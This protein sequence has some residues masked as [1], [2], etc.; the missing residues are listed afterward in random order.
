[1]PEEPQE[2]TEQEQG[3]LIAHARRCLEEQVR[4]G[5]VSRTDDAWIDRREILR[6]KRGLFVTLKKRGELRG[7]IGDLSAS[8]PLHLGVRK[9]T[10]D[11]AIH[12]PRF[13]AVGPD[14]LDEI[15]LSISILTPSVPIEYDDPEEL[16]TLLEPHRDGVTLEFE[17][18]RSTFLPQVWSQLPE[19][20]LF[21]TRLC[22]KQ[23]SPRNAWRSP[24]A[25]VFRYR[26]CVFGETEDA[27]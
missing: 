16:L 12:D 4:E 11:A 13:P 22:L 21:L 1:V 17:G 8:Q 23:G 3:E 9:A 6:K 24:A 27:E 7:C 19:P 25:R 26:A 15:E 2:P 10:V 20:E 5:R 18:R 14:E